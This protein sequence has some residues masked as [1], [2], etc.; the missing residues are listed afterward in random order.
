MHLRLR[1]AVMHYHGFSDARQH[2]A[3]AL[4]LLEALAPASRV[5][6]EV[7]VAAMTTLNHCTRRYPALM[8]P[9]TM[10]RVA[11]FRSLGVCG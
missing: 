11:C 8:S 7:A 6:V 9:F 2:Q 5:V 4:V 3:H 10:A 1:A